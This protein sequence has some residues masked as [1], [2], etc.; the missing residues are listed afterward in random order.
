M[1]AKLYHVPADSLPA[2]GDFL[3]LLQGIHESDNIVLDMFYDP[4]RIWVAR[5]GLTPWLK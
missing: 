4:L 5:F 3:A 2:F 1:L